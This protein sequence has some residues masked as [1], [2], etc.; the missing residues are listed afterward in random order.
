MMRI[1][2][3]LSA[4]AINRI[5]NAPD[6]AATFARPGF[7]LMNFVEVASRHDDH[8]IL[9]DGLAVAAIAEWSAPM[10]WQVHIMAR[11]GARGG[12]ARDRFRECVAFMFD[13]L[14]DR[15]WAQIDQNGHH[16]SRMARMVGFRAT[17]SGC[18]PAIGP[19]T[20]WEARKSW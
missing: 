3:D 11:E 16:V 5:A 12:Y 17:G 1:Y 19:V 7:G 10:V 6:V 15:L 18:S 2:R 9:T 4:D 14:A 13:G 8:V 20:Y